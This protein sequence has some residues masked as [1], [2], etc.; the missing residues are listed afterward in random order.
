MCRRQRSF[1]LLSNKQVFKTYLRNLGLRGVRNYPHY[2]P[3]ILFSINN[4]LDW[5]FANSGRRMKMTN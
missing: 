3:L 2:F 5:C 4:T 1:M